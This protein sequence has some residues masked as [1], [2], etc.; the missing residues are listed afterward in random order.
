MIGKQSLQRYESNRRY[1][2]GVRMENNPSV[3][4]DTSKTGSSSCQ[5]ATRQ[6]EDEGGVAMSF[7]CPNCNRIL[8][9]TWA[10]RAEKV[11]RTACGNSSRLIMS[12][13]WMLERY[14]EAR[15]H[16]KFGS[17]KLQKEARMRQSG[18]ARMS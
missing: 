6:L 2:D 14:A 9:W 16:F 8:R 5:L 17:R 10:R 12:A 1:A 11:S 4:L 15:E 18:R 3:N 7:L 13:P